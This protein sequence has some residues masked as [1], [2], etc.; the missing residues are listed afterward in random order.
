MHGNP[1]KKSIGELIIEVDE[2][3]SCLVHYT[4]PTFKLHLTSLL[5][6]AQMPKREVEDFAIYHTNRRVFRGEEAIKIV[7]RVLGLDASA[8]PIYQFGGRT[9]S[10]G[11]DFGGYKN[12]HSTYQQSSGF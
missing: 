8:D 6:G 11:Q 10:R 4:H 12:N 7:E 5:P 1:L 2:C 9:N 3:Q